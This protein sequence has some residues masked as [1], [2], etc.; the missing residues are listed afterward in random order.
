M[1]Y[2]VIKLQEYKL[3]RHQITSPKILR[4]QNDVPKICHFRA[5]PLSKI[6]VTPLVLK[7]RH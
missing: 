2:D 6:L 5:S 3:W 7:G 1:N 4:H